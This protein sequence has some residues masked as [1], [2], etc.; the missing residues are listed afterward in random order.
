MLSEGV[1]QA[2]GQICLGLKRKVLPGLELRKIR[3][4]AMDCMGGTGQEGCMGG[5]GRTG[6]WVGGISLRLSPGLCISGS[7]SLSLNL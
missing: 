4:L 7:P 2:T 5:M 6:G 3:P 1:K